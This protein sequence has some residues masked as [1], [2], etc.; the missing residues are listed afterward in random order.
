MTGFYGQ[1]T[2]SMDAKG[3]CILPAKMRSVADDSGNLLLDGEIVLTK[4]LEGCLAVYPEPEW[5]A[6]QERLSSLNFTDK[7]FR[8]FSRRFYSSASPVTPDKNGRILIPGHLI[9][10]ANLEKEL[11]V[12]GVN[13]W[14]EIWNPQLFKYYLDQNA[15]SYE[16]QAAKLFVG[17]GR[18]EE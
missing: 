2:T 12:I 1:Y 3:R 15:G 10:E 8:S 7:P 5:A 9:K 16:E 11:M 14:I 17:D 4:G 6:I 13:R 18:A